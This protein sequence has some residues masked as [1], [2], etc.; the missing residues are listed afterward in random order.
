MAVKSIKESIIAKMV[1]NGPDGSKSST[2]SGSIFKSE[3]V[4]L[5]KF[6]CFLV[7]FSCFLYIPSYV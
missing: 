3:T 2:S 1:N 5:D 7:Y 4:D 6:S